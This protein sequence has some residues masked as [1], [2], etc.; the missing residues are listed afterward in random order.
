MYGVDR[1]LPAGLRAFLSFD[2]QGRHYG[3]IV[4]CYCLGTDVMEKFCDECLYG[5]SY[6]VQAV[7]LG[8]AIIGKGCT[9]VKCINHLVTPRFQNCGYNWHVL[10]EL[11]CMTVLRTGGKIGLA[12]TLLK[13]FDLDTSAESTYQ[14]S[15]T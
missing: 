3:F 14:L 5:G 2:H 1:V 15:L 4:P 10:L 7:K 6:H 9:H 13:A 11:G 8:C 12:H